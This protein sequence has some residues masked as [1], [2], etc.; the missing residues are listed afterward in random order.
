MF[1]FD[2]IEGAGKK[3]CKMQDFYLAK[4]TLYFQRFTY[5]QASSNILYVPFM[6][7]RLISR[8]MDRY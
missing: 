6:G 1:I 7:K 2:D 3:L 5:V 8:H 4:Y